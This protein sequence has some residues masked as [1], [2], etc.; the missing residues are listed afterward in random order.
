[1][2]L[3]HFGLTEPPFS[4]TPDTSYFFSYGH[5]ADALNTLLVA[6]KTGEGF[7][8]V[9]GEVGTGKTLLCRKLLNTLDEKF[10]TAYIPNP[11]VT[12]YGLLTAVAEEL[13]VKI[14]RHYGHHQLLKMITERLIQFTTEG[15]RI[16]LCMDEAQAMSIET[17]ESLRLLTNMETEKNKLLQVVLFAQPELNDKLNCQEIRQLKQR[18]TFSYTLEPIDK[19]GMASY[20][21]HRLMTAGYQGGEL[22]SVSALNKLYKASRGIPR[23]INILSHKSMLVSYGKGDQHV[24]PVH[25]QVAVKDTEDAQLRPHLGQDMMQGGAW[26]AVSLALAAIAGMLVQSA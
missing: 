18:I 4:L 22:F 10:I 16:V 14:D 13:G 8:K 24:S 1:M 9:T 17:L 19:A 2:Y 20:V 26:V 21:T 12:P 23:L 11:M 3:E 7:I 15:K 25:M 6:L 5:Y